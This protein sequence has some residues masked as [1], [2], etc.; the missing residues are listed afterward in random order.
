MPHDSDSVP[1]AAHAK[2][3]DES[4]ETTPRPRPEVQPSRLRLSIP[5][6]IVGA[7]AV[8]GL[9]AFSWKSPDAPV[10]TENVVVVSQ[11]P[12]SLDTC[13][14]YSASVVETT[15]TGLTAHLHLSG[16]GCNVYG[17]DLQALLLTVAYETG[18]LPF[19]FSGALD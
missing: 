16:D 8:I 15:S 19:I 3:D 4:E 18:G 5:Q 6:L 1:V 10:V 7:S 17:P 12:P 9:L 14:G 13:P 2:G 11:P